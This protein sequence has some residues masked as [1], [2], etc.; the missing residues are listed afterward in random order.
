MEKEEK[1]SLFN[2]N[3]TIVNLNDKDEEYYIENGQLDITLK[4]QEFKI[5]KVL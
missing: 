3:D 2:I 4:A 1:I 5:L